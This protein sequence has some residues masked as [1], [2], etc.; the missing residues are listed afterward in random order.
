MSSIPQGRKARYLI[1]SPLTDIAGLGA[2][3]ERITRSL[4]YEAQR[5]SGQRSFVASQL[6]PWRDYSH[7][8]A[9]ASNSVH[10]PLLQDALGDATAWA[11]E[12]EAGSGNRISGTATMI[13]TLSL[14]PNTNRAAW[15]IRMESD[16]DTS[17]A[18]A[19]AD[20][21]TPGIT[22]AH[23][24]A[25]TTITYTPEGGAALNLTPHWSSTLTIQGLAPTDRHRIVPTAPATTAG[26]TSDTQAIG[27]QPALGLRHNAAII[28]AI[29]AGPEG[30]LQINRS[31]A[32]WQYILPVVLTSIQE[33]APSA[34]AISLRLQFEPGSSGV[35]VV[36]AIP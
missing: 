18:A 30:V 12:P 19:P 7:A 3:L 36:Q 35:P 15:A 31:P 27:Y 20:T 6:T 16:G 17:S 14:D 29:E 34:G 28:N 5:L 32:D 23:K 21:R 4:R 1:G 25:T 8:F 22:E 2:G 13:P 24:A 11:Y 10:D 26:L 33:E 9:C